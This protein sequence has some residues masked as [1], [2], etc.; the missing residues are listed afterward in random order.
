MKLE[1]GRIS[2]RALLFSVVCFMQGTVLR[3]GFITSVTQNDSW[4]MALSGLAVSLV[5]VAIY[6]ALMHRFPEKNL[7]EISEQALGGVF[8]RAVCVLYLFFF[9]T[10][11]ALNT[12]D[13]G[14]FVVGYMMPE[15]PMPAVILLF[16]LV[17]MYSIKKGIENLIHLAA[18]L[19][20]IALSMVA[21]NVILILKDLN[22]A[23]LRPFFQLPFSKYLQATL[24]VAALPM[25][26]ILAFTMIT[27]ML[28][29]KKKA[30]K[31][32]A[33]GLSI[34]AIY[35]M[36]VLLRDITTLGPM[37]SVLLIPSIESVR[38]ISLA[39]VLTR[40]ESL[41]AVITICLFLFKVIILLYAFIIGIA[42]LFRL[43][44]YYTVLRISTA[45]VFFYSLIVFKSA[46]ENADWGA[47]TAPIF[48]LS[49]ELL[50]PA[51]TLGVACLRKMGSGVEEA[52][53]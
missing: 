39:G 21:V 30:G 24:T 7:F 1:T 4:A 3:A 9:L 27:P 41:Y 11:A 22:L 29:A 40:I 25:G 45:L 32:F 13:L 8:G 53:Q 35:M 2:E 23:Y 28:G 37:I 19:C 18:A 49:F 26:E 14:D 42:Q 46:M 16:L 20:F 34:S 5:F 36:V 51:V 47:T 44:S 50:I 10:L 38:Y 6:S 43:K 31:I 48:S 15:T 12:H 17:C 33:L 52:T